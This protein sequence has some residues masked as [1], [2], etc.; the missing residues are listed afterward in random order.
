MFHDT[1]LQTPAR[2]CGGHCKFTDLG[3]LGYFSCKIAVVFFTSPHVQSFLTRSPTYSMLEPAARI[4]THASDQP[5]QLA[6]ATKPRERSMLDIRG[7]T[8]THPPNLPNKTLQ[9]QQC[10]QT[11]GTDRPT[12]TYTP[13]NTDEAPQPNQP[14][15]P[16]P[17]SSSTRERWRLF[18]IFVTL[19][20]PTEVSQSRASW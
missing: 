14:Y 5:D 10:A 20:V 2:Y 4:G 1:F 18:C 17:L 6:Q 11:E 16:N 7:S 12:S 15:P 9:T 8:D 19:K 3:D 13:D